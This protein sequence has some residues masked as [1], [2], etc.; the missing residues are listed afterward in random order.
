MS[1][2]ISK[3]YLPREVFFSTAVEDDLTQLLEV[4][5]EITSGIIVQMKQFIHRDALLKGVQQWL[6]GIDEEAIIN[7]ISLI[8]TA[9]PN[10]KQII[11]MFCYIA[12]YY[13]A[14]YPSY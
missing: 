10:H 9:L 4:E 3:H 6:R 5:V 1:V 2:Y 13:E 11:W 7:V 8:K 12:V 14:N